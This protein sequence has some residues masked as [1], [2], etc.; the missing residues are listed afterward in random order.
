MIRGRGSRGFTLLEILVALAVASLGILA[1]SRSAI[2]AASNASMLNEQ[3]LAHWVAMN[4]MTE[5]RLE[6]QWPD[7][8]RSDGEVE[9]A[10]LNALKLAFFAREG[11]PGYDPDLDFDGDG[12]IEFV[13][14][15]TM[16]LYFFGPPGPSGLAG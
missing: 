7:I 3:T 12:E 14:L 10:D 9:F 5:I 4:R 11:D 15:N 16:K 1:V 8:G 6:P 13:E 2:Q